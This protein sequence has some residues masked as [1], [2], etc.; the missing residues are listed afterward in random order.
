[1]STVLFHGQ[2]VVFNKHN[3]ARVA[4]CWFI[5]YYIT[6]SN[7]SFQEANDFIVK[8]KSEPTYESHCTMTDN[9]T[10]KSQSHLV[11]FFNLLTNDGV[12]W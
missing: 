12:K 6:I 8:L 10:L 11:M 4:S 5:I 2:N 3:T 7:V 1:M 9:I